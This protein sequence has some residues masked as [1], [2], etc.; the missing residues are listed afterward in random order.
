M[1]RDWVSSKLNSRYGLYQNPEQFERNTQIQTIYQI[2]EATQQL[3]ARFCLLKSSSIPSVSYRSPIH[4]AII[5]SDNQPF[6][7][8]ASSRA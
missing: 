8:K 4:I 2:V 3:L 6:P 7:L 5:H 1:R